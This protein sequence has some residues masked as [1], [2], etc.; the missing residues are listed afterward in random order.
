MQGYLSGFVRCLSAYLTGS[1]IQHI[2]ELRKC[3][4]I[5]VSA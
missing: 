3:L 5:N 1:K 4:N 2:F